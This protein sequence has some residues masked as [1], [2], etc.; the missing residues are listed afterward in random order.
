MEKLQQ[1]PNQ[2][3]DSINLDYS[4]NRIYEQQSG[5]QLGEIIAKCVTLTSLK[6]NLSF[7]RIDEDGVKHLGKGIAKCASLTSLDLVL[8]QNRV[9]VTGA[10]HLGEGIAKCVALSHFNLDLS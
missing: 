5:K 3:I 4:T 2:L 10:K 1:T 9:S 6:L 7:N 8:W